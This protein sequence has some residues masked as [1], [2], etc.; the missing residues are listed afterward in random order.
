VDVLKRYTDINIKPGANVTITYANNNQTKK[1]DITITSTGG[2]GGGNARSI[3]SVSTA[4]N[5]AAAALTDYVYL[6]SGTMT[7][8][9]PDATSGNVNLYTIKNVGTGV[10]T[11]NTTS[12]QTID[13]DLTKVMPVQF[14]SIDLVSDTANWSIT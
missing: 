13:G 14:T 11:V 3:N 2:G 1:V 12:S 7:L 10:I 6:C 8:T 9:M 5:A 4:T